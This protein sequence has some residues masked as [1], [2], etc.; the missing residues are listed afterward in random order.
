MPNSRDRYVRTS[1]AVAPPRCASTAL[2]TASRSATA[3][4]CL[5]RRALGASRATGAVLAGRP[6]LRLSIVPAVLPNCVSTRSVISSSLS[7]FAS[8]A[9][10]ASSRASCSE[11]RCLSRPISSDVAICTFPRSLDRSMTRQRDHSAIIRGLTHADTY[12]G[13]GSERDAGIT[14]GPPF[15]QTPAITAAARSVYLAYRIGLPPFSTHAKTRQGHKITC[16]RSL[17]QPI[18]YGSGM[19]RTG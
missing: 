17:L 16:H 1:F 9:L 7:S 12:I 14:L 3:G 5:R 15:R 19:F 2:K 6:L 8:F 4:A 10:S 11:T 18:K 13:E